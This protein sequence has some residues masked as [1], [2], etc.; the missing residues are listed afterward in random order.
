[1]ARIRNG[2]LGGFSN[3]VGEV[4]G[5]NYAGI[6]TMRAM[7][8]YVSN[9]Q[10]PA[11][12][13]HRKLWADLAHIMKEASYILMSTLWNDNKVYN[14][15]NKAM[16]YNYKNAVINSSVDLSSLVFGQVIGGEFDNLNFTFEVAHE[17]INL[18]VEWTS[19]VNNVDKFEDDQAILIVI[20]EKDVEPAQVLFAEYLTETRGVDGTNQDVMIPLI[21]SK[22][23]DNKDYF[24]IYWGVWSPDT[25][26]VV[27]RKSAGNNTSITIPAHN[28]PAF[29]PAKSFVSEVKKNNNVKS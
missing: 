15:F 22:L 3:K 26:R 12:Q 6:S 9:P 27:N 8:K 25:W 2:I 13:T 18:E 10:T 19:V 4:I 20:L 28:I 5:Q 29:K 23:Y 21:D 11:Q 7:P 17:F 16:K 14:G 24:H 1:M